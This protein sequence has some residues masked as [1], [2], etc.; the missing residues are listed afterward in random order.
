MCVYVCCRLLSDLKWKMHFMVSCPTVIAN[1]SLQT[2]QFLSFTALLPQLKLTENYIKCRPGMGESESRPAVMR[3][4]P[5]RVS[6]HLVLSSLFTEEERDHG[7][8]TTLLH[9]K[10]KDWIDKSAQ[11]IVS[12][13]ECEQLG[14]RKGNKQT[15]DRIL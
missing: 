9:L 11:G 15:N 3:Q 13:S 6:E 5:D 8:A 2:D 4:A 7:Q 1:Q 14:T 12:L 10:R